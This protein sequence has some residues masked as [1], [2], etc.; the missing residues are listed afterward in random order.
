MATG[1]YLCILA[2]NFW[3]TVSSPEQAE[4]TYETQTTGEAPPYVEKITVYANVPINWENPHVWVWLDPDG[5]NAFSSWPGGAMKG[6]DGYWYSIKVP[7]WIN[8]III[9]AN[10]GSVQTSDFKGL[11]QGSDIWVVVEDDGTAHI[12]H[13][14]P[15]IMDGPTIVVRIIVPD[16]W[17]E[18]HLWAWLDGGAS[19]FG[20]WPGEPFTKNGDWYEITVP[21]WADCFIINAND[22]DVQ[23]EDI[24]GAEAGRDIWIV[25]TSSTSY[26]YDY[27][28]IDLSAMGEVKPEPEPEPVPEQATPEPVSPA[29]VTP[30]PDANNNILWVVL[31][32][33]AVIALAV[34]I[35][36][37]MKKKK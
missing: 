23:T 27:E 25:V 21:D 7:A 4:V 26:V 31:A 13:E 1:S 34:I 5:T 11:E 12:Y 20:S 2:N 9:N 19:M 10:D 18:P 15:D 32:V 16:D 35:V 24:K 37:V 14:N 22:G 33:I 29:E 6:S 3:V 17:N 30:E 8:S 36:V 28:E